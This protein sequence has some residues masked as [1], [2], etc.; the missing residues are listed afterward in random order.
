MDSTQPRSEP[1]TE[2]GFHN[3]TTHRIPWFIRVIW[4]GFWVG[5]VWYLIKYGIPSAKNY[6]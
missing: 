5:L 1:K 3:Y 2:R 6:F 4:I